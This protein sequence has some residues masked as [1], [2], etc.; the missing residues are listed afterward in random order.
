MRH[1]T[2]QVFI[3]LV[4]MSSKFG[5]EPIKRLV[6]QVDLRILDVFPR[7]CLSGFLSSLSNRAR[8]I[9]AYATYYTLKL[10]VSGYSD[11]G[12]THIIISWI[13]WNLFE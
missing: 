4:R 12:L 8:T 7:C 10:I 5:A 2:R 6:V 11:V 1:S 9:S 3:T 13:S